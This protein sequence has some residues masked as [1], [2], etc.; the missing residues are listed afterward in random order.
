[1]HG[2]LIQ[3]SAPAAEPITTDEA[4]AH[5]KVTHSSQDAYI[6]ALISAA[7]EQIAGINGWLGRCLVEETFDMKLDFFPA[8][9]D[10]PMAPLR[11]VTSITY[12][13]SNG[14]SQTLDP[15]LYQVF[16]VG[17]SMGGA[18]QPAYEQNWPTT[19]DVPEAV[20]VR[21]V[22]GY[23]SDGLSPEDHAAN[24]PTP[25]KEALKLLVKQAFDD[26]D[27]EDPA[28]AMQIDKAV[29]RLLAPYRTNW[30]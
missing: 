6:A 11:S 15:S 29:E 19:Y 4:K 25:I 21:F 5:L 23:P 28:G 24:V 2:H 7:R 30:I 3:V 10:V 14:D 13:D 16:G 17:A 1:M 27:A 26:K 20:T 22:A 8:C 12:L 9:I 18:I